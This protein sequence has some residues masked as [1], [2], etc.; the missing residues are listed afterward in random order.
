MMDRF[1]PYLGFVLLILWPSFIGAEIYQWTD[2][3]RII[4]FTDDFSLIPDS[5]RDS[6]K[7]IIRHEAGTRGKSSEVP[8]AEESPLKEV[9]PEPRLPEAASSREQELS[10]VS[11]PP[12][13]YYSPPPVVYYVP[14][15]VQIVVVNPL[16]RHPHKNPCPTPGGCKPAFRPNFNDR[17]FIHP[18]VFNGGSRQFIHP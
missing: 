15:D 4:H 14:Q 8:A 9:I 3:K 11:F 18:S 6:P 1:A 7:L 16:V 13:V 2:P 10:G 5:L 17:R 12:V